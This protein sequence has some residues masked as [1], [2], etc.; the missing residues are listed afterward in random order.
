MT[1]LIYQKSLLNFLLVIKRVNLINSFTR[2]P[3]F[4]VFRSVAFF[5]A[6]KA[7]FFFFE[8]SSKK[9]LKDYL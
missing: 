8:D 4:M 9:N 1:F 5:E 3:R 6:K 2:D 7:T